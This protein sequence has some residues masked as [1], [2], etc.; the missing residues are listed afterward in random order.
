[1]HCA[2]DSVPG[3]A[4]GAVLVFALVLLSLLALLTAAVTESNLLQLR[5]VPHLEARMRARQAA[6]GRIETLLAQQELKAPVGLVGERHCPRGSHLEACIDYDLSPDDGVEGYI[7]VLARGGLPPRLRPSL[8][9]SAVA[10]RAVQYEVSVRARVATAVSQ[11][12]QGVVV[13]E[14]RRE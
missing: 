9:S 14:P 8:A 7:E 1:M 5:L 2:R 11:L 10:Y 4:R 12:H 3:R 6:L 13:L